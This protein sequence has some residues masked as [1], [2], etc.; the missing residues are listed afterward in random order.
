MVLFRQYRGCRKEKE[1]VLRLGQA[2]N[3]VGSPDGNRVLWWTQEVC[4][5]HE[6]GCHTHTPSI[7]MLSIGLEREPWVGVNSFALQPQQSLAW[8]YM[9]GLCGCGALWWTQE[10]SCWCNNSIITL[11]FFKEV[12][13]ALVGRSYFAL[14]S[15]RY[16]WQKVVSRTGYAGSPCWKGTLWWI[17]K[18]WYGH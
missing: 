16:I 10:V 1:E 6:K 7:S 11:L 17:H 13:R 8:N 5:V 9:D 12:L 3:R 2:P 14:A 4:C 15:A 18:I